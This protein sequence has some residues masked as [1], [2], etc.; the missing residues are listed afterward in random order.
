MCAARSAPDRGKFNLSPTSRGNP[1]DHS[2]E[3]LATPGGQH[4]GAGL[5]HQN[6]NTIIRHDRFA[7]DGDIRSSSMQS[8]G[9]RK[10]IAQPARGT[11]R[12]LP[13]RRSRSARD[14]VS[15]ILIRRRRR[16]ST[17]RYA[18]PISLPILACAKKLLRDLRR[19][20]GLADVASA[21]DE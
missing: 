11:P 9:R 14:I 4:R 3:E 18:G 8:T 12:A 1:S 19:N 21:I 10:D 7:G 16:R 20:S 2:P 6:M 15:Q 13:E 5:R 17:C